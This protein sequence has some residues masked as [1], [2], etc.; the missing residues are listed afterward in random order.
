MGSMSIN[1]YT[2]PK[3]DLGQSRHEY[4][5][6]GHT[7][8]NCGVEVTFWRMYLA[9]GPQHIRCREC[10][11]RIGFDELGALGVA[12]VVLLAVAGL[13]SWFAAAWFPFPRFVTWAALFSLSA[14]LSSAPQLVRVRARRRL[15]VFP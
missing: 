15:R 6:D 12:W 2:P 9:L 3:S 1:P 13:A 4:G 11:A 5:P 10:R 14:A 7:C 8:P